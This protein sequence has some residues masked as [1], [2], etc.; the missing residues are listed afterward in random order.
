MT[1]TPEVVSEDCLGRLTAAAVV[2]Y[3][4]AQASQDFEG[5]RFWGKMTDALRE[6]LA[7]RTTMRESKAALEHGAHLL[8]V[9]NTMTAEAAVNCDQHATQ[10][11]ALSKIAGG[12]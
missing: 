9:A 6:L 7:I 5:C 4:S 3:D 8:D 2:E 11:R 12:G 10:L 1:D